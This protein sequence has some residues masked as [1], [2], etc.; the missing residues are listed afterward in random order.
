LCPAEGT[1]A[2]DVVGEIAHVLDEL[3]VS[4]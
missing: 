1:I 2:R 4:Q 3:S